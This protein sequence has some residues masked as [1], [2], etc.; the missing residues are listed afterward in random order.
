MSHLYQNATPAEGAQLP[1]GL[2]LTRLKLYPFPTLHPIWY[3]YRHLSP[4]LFAVRFASQYFSPTLH[5]HYHTF[6]HFNARSG[7][8][9]PQGHRSR[10]GWA[11]LPTGRGI[12]PQGQAIRTPPR[13]KASHHRRGKIAQAGHSLHPTHPQGHTQSKPTGTRPQDTTTHLQTPA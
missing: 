2:Q 8:N 5:P 4:I 7:E 9:P 11:Q 6:P 13:G 12:P 3:K 1:H 10:T